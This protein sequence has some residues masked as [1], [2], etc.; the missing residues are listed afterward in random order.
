MR[1]CCVCGR[2]IAVHEEPYVTPVSLAHQAC[3]DFAIHV[4]ILWQ[5][6]RIGELANLNF[7]DTFFVRSER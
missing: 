4:A 7:H 2:D 6:G 5:E 3:A 1:D